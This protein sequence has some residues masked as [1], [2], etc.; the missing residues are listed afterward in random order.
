MFLDLTF[1]LQHLIY[2]GAQIL[3]TYVSLDTFKT[4]GFGPSS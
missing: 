2:L 1:L 3:L 4:L